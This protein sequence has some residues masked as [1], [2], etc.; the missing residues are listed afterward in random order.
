MKN[1]QPETEGDGQQTEGDG[2]Q[3]EG[4]GEQRPEV[5]KIGEAEKTEK[6]NPATTETTI[7]PGAESIPDESGTRKEETTENPDG[8]VDIKK[9]TLTPGTET[10]TTTG[11]GTAQRAT[12]PRMSILARS[13]SIWKRSWAMPASTGILQK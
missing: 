5:E 7:K 1:S 4:D 9:P 12:P 10:T 8:S 2:Q 11:T 6:D 3:T 13:R